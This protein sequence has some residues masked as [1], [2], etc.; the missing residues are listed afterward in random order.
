MCNKI[1]SVARRGAREGSERTGLK[2]KTREQRTKQMAKREKIKE[3]MPAAKA[4]RRETEGEAGLQKLIAGHHAL[5]S[6]SGS[7]TKQEV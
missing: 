4:A 5:R 1:A 7:S 3:S 6:P 2:D